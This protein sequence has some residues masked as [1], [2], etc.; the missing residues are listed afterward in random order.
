MHEVVKT[1]PT[2]PCFPGGSVSPISSGR[3]RR[4]ANGRV[5]S[6]DGAGTGGADG[7]TK[8]CGVGGDVGEEEVESVDELEVG[9]GKFAAAGCGAD[10]VTG[11]EVAGG[12][13]AA[14]MPP[15]GC[16]LSPRGTRN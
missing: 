4:T 9:D 7:G 10:S 2:R 5:S 13:S 1:C 16:L 6:G 3:G 11:I 12:K 8:F 15:S 14:G